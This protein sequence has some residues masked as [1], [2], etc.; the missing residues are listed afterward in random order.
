MLIPNKIDL[1]R[2]NVDMTVAIGSVPSNDRQRVGDHWCGDEFR[3]VRIS[4]KKD[5]CALVRLYES[6]AFVMLQEDCLT[7]LSDSINQLLWKKGLGVWS[8]I[9][10]F[11]GDVFSAQ[12]A[13]KRAKMEKEGEDHE[14]RGNSESPTPIPSFRCTCYRSGDSHPFGSMDAAR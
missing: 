2:R 9:S 5:C 12:T 7:R 14:D 3:P 10:S 1:F 6:D 11:K 13:H 4:G 8:K